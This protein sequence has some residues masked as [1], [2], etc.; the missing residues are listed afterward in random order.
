MVAMLVATAVSRLIPWF[1]KGAIEELEQGRDLSVVGKYVWWMIGAAAVSGVLLYFQRWFI[2]TTARK[3]EY[4]IRRD[5][6]AHVQRLDLSF[7]EQRKTGDLM[8]HFTND[9]NAVRAVAGR[10]ILYASSTLAMLGMSVTAMLAIS[11]RLTA[12]AF[13]PYPIVS[14]CTFFFGKAMLKRARRVQDI[15]GELSSRVQEDLAGVRVIRAYCQENECQERF[16]TLN[17]D[18]R[19]ANLSVAHLRGGFMAGMSALA[20]TGLALALLVGGRSVIAGEMSLGSL[21]AF[22]VYLAELMWPVIAIGWIISVLQRGASAAGRL[23]SVLSV[24]PQIASG[25]REHPPKPII[26]FENVSFRH[27]GTHQNALDDVSFQLKR[28]Q[29]LGIV[30][31]IGSG[32]STI[33]KLIERF[34]DPTYGRIV[35]DGVD[36]RERNIA[37]VRAI[38]GYVPQEPLLFSRTIAENIA[39]GRTK[40]SWGEIRNVAEQVQ[41]SA[42]I[43]KF[44][45]GLH[46]LVGERGVTLSGGQRQRVSLARALIVKPEL[47]LLDDTLSSVDANTE[48]QILEELRRITETRT[49]IIASHRI[50]A[51]EHADWIL[52]LDKGRV[53]Q[54]GTH[55]SLLRRGGLYAKI[56]E[57]QRLKDV[58][59][60]A[61]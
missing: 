22:S 25:V 7:F 53:C 18:Y 43:A 1:L 30:G 24:M 45:D 31:R 47:L 21:V 49:S 41:L 55:E 14:L 36:I 20:G 13:A 23:N 2:R 12:V 27:R 46:S 32:K 61:L 42:E 19:S 11:P 56:Y 4:D 3:V 6:F 26:R 58:L 33:L 51:V 17:Q 60:G 8:A 9:L 57:Q 39:Y 52:V 15:F 40:V 59:E 37:A 44:K 34:Y 48:K 28:G 5:L 54:E 29:T 35:C 38:T 50:S 16:E 10:G